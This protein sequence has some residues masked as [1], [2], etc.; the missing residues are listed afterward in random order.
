MCVYTCVLNSWVYFIYTHMFCIY[1]AIIE[2]TFLYPP[3]GAPAWGFGV[4]AHA[5]LR[6]GVAGGCRQSWGT[7]LT[8]GSNT[9]HRRGPAG[10]LCPPDTVW[11]AHSWQP[12]AMKWCD[13]KLYCHPISFIKCLQHHPR[14]AA[15]PLTCCTAKQ[16][17]SAP[18]IP[19]PQENYTFSAQRWSYSTEGWMTHSQMQSEKK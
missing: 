10:C 16:S 1:V 11:E 17:P 14:K 5:G 15:L 8:L 12:E 4:R 13:S 18:D 6:V 3:V 7:N 9:G 2:Y 19:I